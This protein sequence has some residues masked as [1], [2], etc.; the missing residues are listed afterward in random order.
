MQGF[1]LEFKFLKFSIADAELFI[2][3]NY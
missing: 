2:A 1:V 3:L